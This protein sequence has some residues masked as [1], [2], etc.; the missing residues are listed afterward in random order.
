M[1][2]LIR[3]A[4]DHGLEM[5]DERERAGKSRKGTVTLGASQRGERIII[6]V[7]DDGRGMNPEILRR[8][9]VEKGVIDG[10]S[11]APVRE[12]MLRIDFPPWLQHGGHGL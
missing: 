4:L 11:I 12:R 7:S 9:A 1:V 6:T 8:K 10:A 3:N 5:P 2:H